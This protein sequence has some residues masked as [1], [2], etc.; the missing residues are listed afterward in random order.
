MKEFEKN[1]INELLNTEELNGVFLSGA[2]NNET[3][4]FSG[5]GYFLTVKNSNFPKQRIVLD[6]P[7]I[8]GMLGGVEVGYLVFVEDSEL[9]LECYS[10]EKEVLPKHRDMEF[11]RNAT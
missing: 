11:V 7:T 5:T 3:T 2:L 10:Y 6:K 8:N 1:I 4:E 9:T